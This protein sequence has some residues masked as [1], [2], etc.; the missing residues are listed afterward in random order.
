M[1]NAFVARELL[2]VA[3]EL[4]EARIDVKSRYHYW[5]Q[6]VFNGKLPDIP[7][8]WGRSKRWGGITYG[9][10]DRMARTGTP[11]RI[12]ISDYIRDEINIIDGIMLHEMI[13]VE[14]ILEG[15]GGHGMWFELKRGDYSRKSGLDIPRTEA[16]EHFVVPEDVEAKP[17][18]VV[19]YKTKA[20]Q[21]L[22]IYGLKFFQNS[23]SILKNI[24]E[25]YVDFYRQRGEQAE[26]TFLISEVKD[27][28]KYPEKRSVMQR[29]Y[30]TVPESL[31]NQVI[32]TGQQVAQVAA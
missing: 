25:R 11:Q 14:M 32:S 18:G 4:L 5:N 19:I 12:E 16:M 20:R 8:T 21:G 1:N 2:I 22:V 27:L 28:L 10:L 15:H 6:A 17:K 30:Y 29:G 7:V 31:L 26:V 13:H 3:R 23:L 9:T 24:A